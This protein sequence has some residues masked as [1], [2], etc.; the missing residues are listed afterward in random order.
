MQCNP[1]LEEF[2]LKFQ[3]KLELQYLKAQNT[4]ENKV[5]RENQQETIGQR[6]R[7]VRLQTLELDTEY[8]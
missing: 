2:P 1:G 4:Q 7:S 8:K 3:G 5:K 6:E